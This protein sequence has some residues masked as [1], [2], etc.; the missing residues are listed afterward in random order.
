M[1]D[2]TV[3][4]VCA[5]VVAVAL[6]VVPVVAG[7][8]AAARE[9]RAGAAEHRE[10]VARAERAEGRAVDAERQRDALRVA[11]TRYLG[12]LPAAGAR[13]D[14]DQLRLLLDL[15]RDAAGPS[16]PVAARWDGDG[17]GLGSLG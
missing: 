7:E 15:T 2:P 3:I 10:A 8:L 6:L 17:A 12:A 11:A 1:P 13:P 5:A 9:R 16:G 4:V 14:D